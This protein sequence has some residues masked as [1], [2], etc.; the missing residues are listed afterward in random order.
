MSGTPTALFL[1]GDGTEV[2][3]LPG[4]APP[5]EKHHERV[6]KVLRGVDTFKA[7][8]ERHA[9]APADVEVATKLAR[10]YGQRRDGK[11]R[12]LELYKEVIAADPQGTRGMTESD[13]QPVS[14]AEFAEFSL[15]LAAA[16]GAGGKP[17]P[18]P[19]NGFMAKYPSSRMMKK[20][21]MS[22][23]SYH[24]ATPNHEEATRYYESI[25]EKFPT[26][27]EVLICYVRWAI[28]D[29]QNVDRG[30]EISEKIQSLM[31]TVSP[32]T[33]DFYARSLAE[34][35][36]L[37]DNAAKAEEVYGR[38]YI[39]DKADQVG[40]DLVNYARFW[41]EMN[42][43]M[44]STVEMMETALRLDPENPYFLESAADIYFQLKKPDKALAI[45]GPEYAKKIQNKAP[46]LTGYARYWND[47]KERLDDALAAV[48][49]AIAIAPT[50]RAWD[51]AAQIYINVGRYD[52]A[53]KAEE[54]A[55]KLAGSPNPSYDARLKQIKAA[56]EKK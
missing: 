13:G 23:V 30:I 39:K 2:D 26:D 49:S 44:E 17:D 24:Y 45:Y 31:K 33:I 52:E 12:S 47:R 40:Y 38:K 35:Y 46:Y 18:G 25:I 14:C 16:Q 51:I 9:K 21:V 6:L 4:Y 48:L 27:P 3:W 29:K 43:N 41:S 53:L 7:L 19:M 15:A 5:A 28:K 37:K 56:L 50:A 20:A 8:I 55:I 34:L 10:K 42:K 32:W 1:E 36:L 11:A 54:T 22:L